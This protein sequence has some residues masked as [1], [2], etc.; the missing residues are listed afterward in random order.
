VPVPSTHVESGSL[1]TET[2]FVGKVVS[3]SP[4]CTSRVAWSTFDKEL[5]SNLMYAFAVRLPVLAVTRVA[6]PPKLFDATLESAV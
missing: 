5:I 6:S 2:S 1:K 3:V 4:P